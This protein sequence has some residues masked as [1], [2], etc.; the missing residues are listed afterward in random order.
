MLS[1]SYQFYL[2]FLTVADTAVR[3]VKE[4][5]GVDAGKKY[6]TVAVNVA[7]RVEIPSSS[8]IPR[9]YPAFRI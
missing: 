2:G 6:D 4:E 7:V 5:T 1:C 3:E 9:P 8:L